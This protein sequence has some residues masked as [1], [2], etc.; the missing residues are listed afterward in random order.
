MGSCHP[1]PSGFAFSLS[2][3]EQRHHQIM[4]PS[5]LKAI[6]MLQ[7]IGLAFDVVG[8]LTWGGKMKGTKK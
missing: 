5:L 1:T 2:M 3:V 7:A 8:L 4:V 6:R